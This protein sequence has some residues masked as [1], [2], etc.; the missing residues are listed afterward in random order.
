MTQE[1]KNINSATDI[2]AS[3]LVN[4]DDE[5]EIKELLYSYLEGVKLNLKNI[6][7]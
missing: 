5:K 2:L 3:I 4:I 1:E 6:N 7:H